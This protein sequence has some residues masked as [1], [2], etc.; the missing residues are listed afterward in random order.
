MMKFIH[1]LLSTRFPEPE[2]I[3]LKLFY[4]AFNGATTIPVYVY[5]AGYGTLIDHP[6]VF[7]AWKPMYEEIDTVDSLLALGV[8]IVG[9]DVEVSSDDDP[10]SAV[11]NAHAV[12]CGPSD[13][14]VGITNDSFTATGSAFTWNNAEIDSVTVAI[15]VPGSWDGLDVEIVNPLTGATVAMV[16]PSNDTVEFGIGALEVTA[17]RRLHAE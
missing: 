7:D 8:P 9:A 17:I 11:P 15:P 5:W 4:S 2:E 3:R 10:G 12:W 16:S 14:V 6:D 13:I 1:A